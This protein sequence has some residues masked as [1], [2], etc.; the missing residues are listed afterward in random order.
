MELTYCG[1]PAI[2]LHYTVLL[3]QWVNR[4]LPVKGVSSSRPGDAWT[5]NGTAFLLLAL[6]SYISDPDVIDHLITGLA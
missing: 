1:G 3:V 2:S 5:H 6:S 4:L